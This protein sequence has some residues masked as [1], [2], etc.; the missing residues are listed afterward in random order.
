MRDQ[1]CSSPSLMHL[2]V[3]DVDFSS[4]T[5][6]SNH[7]H[8]PM[9]SRVARDMQRLSRLSGLPL[10]GRILRRKRD[11]AGV[12]GRTGG[13]W[14]TTPPFAHAGRSFGVS[15]WKVGRVAL[16]S[17]SCEDS[18]NTTELS[19]LGRSFK[20]FLG[21][22]S[23]LYRSAPFLWS[24]TS[25][26]TVL[27]LRL[28]TVALYGVQHHYGSQLLAAVMDGW[29][30]FSRF[31]S[32]QL[33][34]FHRCL[35]GKTGIRDESVLMEQR[36]LQW[37][38]KLL[39]ALKAGNLEDKI[40]NFVGPAAAKKLKTATDTLGL[41]GMTMYQTRHSGASIDRV[42]GF[43]TLQEVQRRGQWEAS[44]VSQD[45]TKAVVWR[46]TTT[47]SLARSE[48]SWKHSRD[49]PRDCC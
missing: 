25:K 24:K 29:P 42:R 8:R 36:W 1:D 11:A 20:P 45:T 14:T 13:V 17:K 31:G 40:W 10:L 23:S 16:G 18:R 21:R 12:E 46:S 43:R 26:S 5:P 32:R 33:P 47:L 30:S 49:V 38:N 34:S 19:I 2:D 41:S 22:S 27:W 35:K 4:H 3:G 44:V 15:R 28:R 39:P 37:V 7:V 9:I 6:R 48:T